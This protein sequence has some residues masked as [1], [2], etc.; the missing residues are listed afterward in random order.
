MK[1]VLLSFLLILGLSVPI[2]S[3][4]HAIFGLSKCE[5]VKKQIEKIEDQIK[6]F[7]NKLRVT[8]MERNTTNSIG[9]DEIEVL[10]PKSK[11]C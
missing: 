1:R 5:R 10:T 7:P 3:P 8:K 2:S 4:A 6:S 11:K 9:S